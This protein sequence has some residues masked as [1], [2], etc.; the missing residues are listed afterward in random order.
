LRQSA[1]DLA[2]G[3]A[4]GREWQLGYWKH[5]PL[6]WCTAEA[7]Y[8]LT[9]S[10]YSVYLLGPLAI[11]ACFYGVWLLAR[12]TI[13]AFRGLIAVL[14]LEG[15]RFYNFS[16]VKFGHDQAQLRSGHSPCLFRRF[17]AGLL[18][19][20]IATPLLYAAVEL[21]EPLIRDRPKATEFPGRTVAEMV[22][23]AWRDRFGT[24]LVA[25]NSLRTMWRSI[26]RI[27]RM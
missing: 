16:S 2:E 4:L 26:R 11:V 1:L 6:P 12:D 9:G 25:L 18:A 15:I 3:L 13:G 8:W 23:R 24:P 7:A 17:A 22:T 20:R 5:P 14:A 27:G 10:I 21:G 19:V